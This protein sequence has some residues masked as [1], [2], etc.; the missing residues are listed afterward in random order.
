MRRRLDEQSRENSLLCNN[1][2]S[3]RI[4]PKYIKINKAVTENRVMK[5]VS[6]EY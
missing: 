4:C 3:N 5:A 6:G 2:E 1:M